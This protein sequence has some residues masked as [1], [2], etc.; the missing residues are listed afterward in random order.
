MPQAKPLVITD[1]IANVLK[2]VTAPLTRAAESRRKATRW[3]VVGIGLLIVLAVV[4]GVVW[5]VR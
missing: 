5:A 3:A 1:A 4:V 2:A